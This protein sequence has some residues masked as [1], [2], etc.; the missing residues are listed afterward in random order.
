MFNVS[1]NGI[2]EVVR[3]DSFKVALFINRGTD[4]CP[5]RYILKEGEYIYFGVME[6][7]YSFENAIV[8]KKYS[9]ET[10]RLGFLPIGQKKIPKLGSIVVG[11]TVSVS[12]NP[13]SPDMAYLTHNVG[14][15]NV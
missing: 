4:L 14:K 13:M 11:D 3:G 12:Y 5:E 6:P 1:K 9:N 8:R 15:I 2:I 10:V 7:N